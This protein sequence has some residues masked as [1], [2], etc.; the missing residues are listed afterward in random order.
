MQLDEGADLVG[1]MVDDRVGPVLDAHDAG[2]LNR[3]Q[4]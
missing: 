4:W 3:H 2:Q 1:D